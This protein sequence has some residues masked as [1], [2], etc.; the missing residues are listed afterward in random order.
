M[1]DSSRL[2]CIYAHGSGLRLLAS[3]PASRSTRNQ[4]V[5]VE[6]ICNRLQRLSPA[7]CGYDQVLVGIRG[8]SFQCSG[9]R[10]NDRSS[11]PLLGRLLSNTTKSTQ[12]T[13]GTQST[14]SMGSPYIVR[15][16]ALW[17][18]SCTPPVVLEPIYLTKGSSTW[19]VWVAT[20]LGRRL[21]YSIRTC[22]RSSSTSP[23]HPSARQ[24]PP[25]HAL[26]LTS[27]QDGVVLH[28]PPRLL[29]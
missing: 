22:R 3:S 4:T 26:S 7:A 6:K 14:H 24:P 27:P 20:H 12:P 18:R 9:S 16:D 5:N 25:V 21:N 8:E 29:R 1:L 28:L 10:T 23:L 19:S 11:S 15:M 17:C 13:R 2:R